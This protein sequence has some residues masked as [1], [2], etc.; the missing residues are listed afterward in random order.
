MV[1]NEIMPSSRQFRFHFDADE[2]VTALDV[3]TAYGELLDARLQSLRDLETRR[4]ATAEP[5]TTPTKRI[6]AP[7]RK[8]KEKEPTDNY[9]T[10]S[11]EELVMKQK[12]GAHLRKI[13]TN[14]TP[15]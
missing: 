5:R 10:L 7:K 12:R 13:W 2:N 8:G 9:E 3:V 6:A 15:E 11:L 1:D 4:P 14:W